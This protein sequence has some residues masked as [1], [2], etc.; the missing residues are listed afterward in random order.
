M[1]NY[2]LKTENLNAYF[3]TNH[4]VKNVNVQFKPNQ[5]VSV[6]GP[7][8]CGKTTFLRCLNR[9][10]ELTPG[11]HTEGKILMHGTDIQELP[12]ILVRSKIGMVFQQPNPFPNMSIYDNVIAGYKLNGVR[13]NKDDR[14]QIVQDALTRAALWDE[15]KDKLG[16]R[17][18]FISGGQQQRLCIARAIALKPDV[19]LMDEPTSALDPKSTAQI[20]ELIQKLKQNYTV[21]V[22]T[23]NM[24]QAKRISDY[25]A[26]FFLGELV[27]YGATKEVF[28]GPADKRTR[29]YISGD[30]S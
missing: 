19:L 11:T 3:G 29:G 4:I 2:I 28:E 24:H 18:A 22:V 13:L 7:S 16:H 1:E 30:F 15:V 6:M 10:H 8:G 14:D 26:F 20:E 27:E 9:M 17:G 25:S 12:P 23:H 5:V 21:I